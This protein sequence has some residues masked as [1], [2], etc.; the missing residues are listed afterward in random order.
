M[1]PVLFQKYAVVS[2]IRLVVTISVSGKNGP[3]L[4]RTFLLKMLPARLLELLLLIS[5]VLVP[6]WFNSRSR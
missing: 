2:Y 4:S 1:I 6:Q 3:W 5:K